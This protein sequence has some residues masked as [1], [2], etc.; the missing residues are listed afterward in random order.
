MHIPHVRNQLIPP[1][2]PKFALTMARP[3]RCRIDICAWYQCPVVEGVD[4]A[5]QVSIAGETKL[6]GGTLGV[7]ARVLRWAVGI[8]G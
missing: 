3:S 5:L 4:V 6:A 2:E 7:E 1:R 8:R